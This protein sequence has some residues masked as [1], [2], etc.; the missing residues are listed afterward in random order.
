MP[1]TLILSPIIVGLK[2]HVMLWFALDEDDDIGREENARIEGEEEEEE[3]EEEDEEEEE[4]KERVGER[5]E[6]E[7]RGEWVFGRLS[8]RCLLKS[9]IVS[10]AF[11]NSKFHVRSFA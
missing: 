11:H 6:I 8:R 1:E 2:L 4:V 5:K 9:L 10:L 7:V 3:E